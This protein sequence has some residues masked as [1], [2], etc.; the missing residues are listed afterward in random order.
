MEKNSKE[1]VVQIEPGTTPGYFIV[2][3][4]DLDALLGREYGKNQC[5]IH[6]PYTGK[7]SGRYDIYF[8]DLPE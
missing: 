1:R 6:V 2:E 4:L 7:T 8:D 5:I 3:H